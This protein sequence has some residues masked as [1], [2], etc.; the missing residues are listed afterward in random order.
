MILIGS[1][2]RPGKKKSFLIIYVWNQIVFELFESLGIKT[3]F[4]PGKYLNLILRYTHADPLVFH[5]Q[6]KYCYR[7][8][9]LLI[10]INKKF[11]FYKFLFIEILNSLKNL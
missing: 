1:L 11:I 10:T 2:D 4:L 3:L 7:D 8:Q 9:T 6:K 5:P